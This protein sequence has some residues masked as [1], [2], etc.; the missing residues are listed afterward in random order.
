MGNIILMEYTKVTFHLSRMIRSKE[1][2]YL[3]LQGFNQVGFSSNIGI[4]Y[5][6]II[7]FKMKKESIPLASIWLCCHC[8]WVRWNVELETSDLPEVVVVW[9][10]SLT[11]ISVTRASLFLFLVPTRPEF[12]FFLWYFLW[13]WW[14]FFLTLIVFAGVDTQPPII[15]TQ[16]TNPTANCC[17]TMRR[18]KFQV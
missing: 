2:K 12:E 10:N 15:M 1:I 16:L 9:T 11:A 13:R 6:K 14:C 5:Q 3:S 4:W 18:C 7:R 17:C 8:N